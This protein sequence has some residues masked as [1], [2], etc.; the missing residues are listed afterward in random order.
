MFS[1]YISCYN[2]KIWI[3]FLTVHF[4]TPKFFLLRIPRFASFSI[5]SAFLFI[6]FRAHNFCAFFW[7]LIF[8]VFLF[9]RLYTL[10]NV[11][12]CICDTLS[13]FASFT[14]LTRL[15]HRVRKRPFRQM[16]EDCHLVN[17]FSSSVKY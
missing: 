9:L 5:M 4:P 1:H 6:T 2:A 17:C 7:P 11:K 10:K 12:F 3:T 8:C 16:H 14:A 13:A 15:S